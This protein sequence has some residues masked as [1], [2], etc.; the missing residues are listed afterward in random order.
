VLVAAVLFTANLGI[1]TR[2]QGESE[3]ASLFAAFGAAGMPIF[4]WL[5]LACSRTPRGASSVRL[6]RTEMISLFAGD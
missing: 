2:S 5:P 6:D 3:R 4:Q 1:A